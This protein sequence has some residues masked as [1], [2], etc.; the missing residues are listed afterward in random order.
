[1]DYNKEASKYN[2]ERLEKQELQ[3]Q[4]RIDLAEAAKAVR[5]P[6]ESGPRS[7]GQALKSR[8]GNFF[9]VVNGY[10]AV[11]DVVASAY[12]GWESLAW[13]AVRFL[14]TAAIKYQKLKDQ[15]EVYLEKIG[16]NF[17]KISSLSKIYPNEQIVD[18]VG[19]AYSEFVKFLENAVRYYKDSRLSKLSEF[20]LPD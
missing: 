6:A 5:Y 18:H 20:H 14:L 3:V 19:S 11:L 12:P 8:V 13:G 16:D 4:E 7:F 17:K 9:L 2:W 15:V 1:M 10:V